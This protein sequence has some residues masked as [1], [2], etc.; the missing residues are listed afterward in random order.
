MSFD[1]EAFV[2]ALQYFLEELKDLGPLFGEMHE[3]EL[4]RPEDVDLGDVAFAFDER[5]GHQVLAVVLDY[6]EDEDQKH[7]VL[8]LQLPILYLLV[9]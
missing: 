6:V 4:C 2:F 9:L 8:H 1:D 7:L 3:L 5:P